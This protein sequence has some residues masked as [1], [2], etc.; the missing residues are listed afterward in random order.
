METRMFGST[1]QRLPV[2]GLGTWATFDV[3][4]N[5]EPRVREVVDSALSTG[6]R[7]F[8]TS[9]MYG[10]AEGALARALAPHRQQAWVATKVWTPSP[11]AGRQQ[12][13]AQL[14]M[15][16]GVIDL[17]QIHNLVAWRAHLRW[18][19]TERDKG[20]I[21]LIGAT[22]YDSAAFA[23]LETVMKTRRIDAIQVPL[24]PLEREA[25]RRILPLAEE[26]GLG[27]I[28]MRPFA[29][30]ALFPGPDE[31]ALSG[32]GVSNWASALIKWIL[33]D[34]RVHVVIPATRRI[35]HVAANVAAAAGTLLD[36]GQRR[37]VEQLVRS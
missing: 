4:A 24:N 11:D 1:G 33:A 7:V 12:F 13:A 26:L 5:E 9:P 21:R 3:P 36:P 6:I 25:E 8:D 29:E 16:G 20:R 18:L 2:I 35:T 14:A 19:E 15:F 27:I 28:V 30:G 31:S 10:R 37:R 34:R 32:L 22:H 17:E 23:D